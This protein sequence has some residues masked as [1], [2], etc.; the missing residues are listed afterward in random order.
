MADIQLKSLN[1]PN[2]GNNYHFTDEDAQEKLS[3]M[4]VWTVN[5]ETHKIVLT[6]YED[7]NSIS[8]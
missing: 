7:G 8:Y 3:A 1:L 2:D 5:T 6:Q 4:P